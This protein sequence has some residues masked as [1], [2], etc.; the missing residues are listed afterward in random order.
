[1]NKL[2][3][4]VKLKELLDR[5]Y[6]THS[7]ILEIFEDDEEIPPEYWNVLVTDPRELRRPI[8]LYTGQEGAEAFR[9][10]TEDKLK[11]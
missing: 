2:E 10:A 6:L 7:L 11:I 3:A 8:V 4:K 5:G 1:M 9:K